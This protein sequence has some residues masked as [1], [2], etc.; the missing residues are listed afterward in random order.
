MYELSVRT[1]FSAA[2]RLV[3]YEGK[4]AAQHG[5][6]WD[7]EVF[8]RGAALSPAGILIDYKDLK[9]VLQEELEE[10]DHADLNRVPGLAGANPS[11]ENLARFLYGKLRVA[12]EQRGLRPAR[13]V[14]HETPETGAA[15]WEEEA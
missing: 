10:V 15:Y 1:R 3:A 8:V 2:H 12:L 14:V 5:H 13:V 6:N 4:C 11:S 9:G 7:V